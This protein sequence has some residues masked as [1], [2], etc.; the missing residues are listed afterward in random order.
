[1]RIMKQEAASI[2]RVFAADDVSA[3]GD[4]VRCSACGRHTSH[5][6]WKDSDKKWSGGSVDTSLHRILFIIILFILFMGVPAAVFTGPAL[7][8]L[9]NF[10]ET[11]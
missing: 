3:W 10:F 9:A 11:T 8:W 6:Q 7:V 4:S 1:M 5:I 2:T